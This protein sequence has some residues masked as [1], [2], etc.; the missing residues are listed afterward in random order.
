MCT[1]QTHIKEIK[2]NSATKLIWQFEKPVTKRP[3]YEKLV[4]KTMYI[5]TFINM[6][7]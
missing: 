5:T 7:T 4:T 1:V 2:T 3:N 6:G